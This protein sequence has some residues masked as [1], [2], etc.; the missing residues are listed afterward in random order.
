NVEVKFL[1]IPGKNFKIEGE[2]ISNLYQYTLYNKTN[3]DLRVKFQLKSHED[4]TIRIIDGPPTVILQK[5]DI[6]QGVVEIS[7]PKTDVSSYKERVVMIAVD[8]EG[9]ELDD[10][11]TSF[12][13]PF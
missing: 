12:A 7:I 13:A 4:G 9:K 2:H 8:E 6:K 10:Y 1:Q 3:A 5:A 11:S